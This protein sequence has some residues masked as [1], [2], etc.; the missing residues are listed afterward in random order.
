MSV[1]RRLGTLTTSRRL[2][3]IL[4]EH[5]E[6]RRRW[7]AQVKRPQEDLHQ[8]AIAQVITQYLWECG[9]LPEG[10]PSRSLKDRVARALNGTVFS[11]ET[12]RWFIEAFEMD[13][14]HREDL[15]GAL[16]FESDPEFGVAFTLRNRRPLAKRQRH[17]TVSLV[18]RYLVGPSRTVAWRRT[19]HAIRAMEDGVDSYFLNYEP[20][21]SRVQVIQGGV[22]GERCDYG[23]GLTGVDIELPRPLKKMQTTALEYQVEFSTDRF[24]ATEVRRPAFARVENIDMAVEFISIST[25]KRLWWCVWDDHLEGKPVW[26]QQVALSSQVARMYVPSVE[27][28]VVGFR[29]EW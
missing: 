9:E 1:D 18:E 11:A 4:A 3:E 13:D 5:P 6:Y 25:P 19:Y 14:S 15:W 12:L 21:A 10:V 29:W 22:L 16:F 26:E 23:N 24:C 28:S 17:R 8:A 20:W 7:Q 2:R 27:E